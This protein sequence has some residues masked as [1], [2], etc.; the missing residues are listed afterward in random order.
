MLSFEKIKSTLEPYKIGSLNVIFY[1]QF[2]VR[3]KAFN[4]MYRSLKSDF[5]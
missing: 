1:I 4:L 5:K 2:I 3:F